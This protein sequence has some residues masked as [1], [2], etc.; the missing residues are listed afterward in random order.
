MQNEKDKIQN[1]LRHGN[2]IPTDSDRE[3]T[4][5]SRIRH[6]LFVPEDL[7]PL[8]ART[9]SRFS[10][11]HGVTA[12][13]VSYGTQFGMRVPAILYMP[14]PLP[15]E[16]IPAFIVVNGHGGDKY[17]WYAFYS[18]ILYARAGAA[19]LTYDPT[20]EGERNAER[21]SG[22]RAHD[23]VE[24]PDELAQRLAGLMITDVMQAVSCLSQRPEVD[25]ARIAA[26]GYSMGSFVLALAGALDTR[27]RACVLVGGGNL[28]GPG[29]RWDCSKPMCQGTPYRS[30]QFLGDR[31]AV[32]YALHASRGPTLIFNGLQDTTVNIPACGEPFFQ[33]LQRRTA[34]LR[35]SDRGV[36][37]TGFVPD[38]AHRPY[39]VTRPV[40]QWLARQIDF[41][42]WT[43]ADIQAM[44]ETHI[45]TWA[46]THGVEM[47][48]LYATE[49]RE[50]GTP[51]LGSG[52]P[53][54][55]RDDLS[56]FS[57]E[58]WENLKAQ[59]T[60]ESWREAARNC[61]APDARPNMVKGKPETME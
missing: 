20:G 54:L 42:R 25:A 18:G 46:Q 34:R 57:P 48:R 33:D 60:H 26:A 28:D 23:K 47:D 5:R 27:L 12:E 35:G 3:H 8:D 55:S 30:L 15:K 53:G 61:I 24:P 4:W 58:E 32:L 40:A 29:E 17:S 50:A 31:A 11:E 19:V 45:G 9:H 1:G 10:P 6:T 38:T 16:K 13:R 43:E 21:K 56:V 51:A 14:D 49:E 52:I 2:D 41:P 22:T 7:P 36:F 37:E 59:L 39:F 44:P